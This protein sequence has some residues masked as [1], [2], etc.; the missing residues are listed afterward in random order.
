MSAGLQSS[1]SKLVV[2]I[3]WFA[4]TASLDLGVERVQD[5]EKFG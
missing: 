4:V 5:G 2:P 3:S 1:K